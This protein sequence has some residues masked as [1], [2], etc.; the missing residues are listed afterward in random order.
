VS[1]NFKL[2]CLPI[3]TLIG[4]VL[5]I[6]YGLTNAQPNISTTNNLSPNALPNASTPNAL[7]NA[8]TPNALPNASTPNA[9]PNAST[10]NALPSANTPNALPSANTPNALPNG[11][12]KDA[13]SSITETVNQVLSGSIDGMIGETVNM[14]TSNT[15]N[16]GKDS[17]KSSFENEL[18]SSLTLGKNN[19]SIAEDSPAQDRIQGNSS[20]N[21]L[22]TTKHIIA[23]NESSS[24]P[25]GEIKQSFQ[26]S[27][28]NSTIV[29]SFDNN[30]FSKLGN[31]NTFDDFVFKMKNILDIDLFK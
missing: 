30:S 18:P 28:Y 14:L 26:K 1:R 6:N 8:S 4:F 19:N 25:V 2:Y 3:I 11:A 29:Q 31:Q 24:D 9:L 17:A 10:P 21:T 12:N 23:N 5:F 7:P 15:A 16:M 13:S 20:N 22:N 27:M